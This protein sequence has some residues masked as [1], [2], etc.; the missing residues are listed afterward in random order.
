MSGH[1]ETFGS[2]CSTQ[3]VVYGQAIPTEYPGALTMTQWP[4]S[5]AT[6]TAASPTLL[7]QVYAALEALRSEL[8]S[9]R[10]PGPIGEGSPESYERDLSAALNRTGR[11]LL[12]AVI[13]E[14]DDSSDGLVVDGVRYYRVG[15]SAG[16]VMSSFS[17]TRFERSLYRRR[18][19]SSLLPAEARFGVIG[20][21]WSLLAARQASLSLSL[22]PA[23]DYYGNGAG[24]SRRRRR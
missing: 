1:G 8:P 22:A 11:R 6:S 16:E 13:E 21:F 4:P 19:C 12:G 2:E 23:R 18:D 9:L 15:V 24:W 17:R 14:L 5:S 7:S 10:L 3:H 20:G